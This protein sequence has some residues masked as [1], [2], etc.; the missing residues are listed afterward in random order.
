[1]VSAGNA[2]RIRIDVTS[3]DQINI[4]MRMKVMPG[5]RIAMIVVRKFRPVS[6]VE[7]PETSRP[8]THQSIARPG[9]K[10]RSVRF[11]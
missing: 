8:T 9:V 2:I 5:A 3:S 11:A 6:T 1:M 7:M 10:Y 4:G